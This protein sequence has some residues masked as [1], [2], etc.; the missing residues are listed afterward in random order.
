MPGPQEIPAAF[1]PN[2]HSPSQMALAM[3][4]QMP[5]MLAQALASVLQ[6]VPVQMAGQFRC[7]QCV[8]TRLGWIAAYQKDTDAAHEAYVRAVTEQAELAPDDPLRTIPLDFTQFLPEPLRPGAGSQGMPPIQDGT[9]MVNGALWCIE[10]VPGAP[11]K[12]QLLIARGGLGA[13]VLASLAA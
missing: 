6:Q 10:H 4:Q 5:Q 1:Q 3:M 13:S 7:T 12:P 9:V 8:M 11:G 2:G